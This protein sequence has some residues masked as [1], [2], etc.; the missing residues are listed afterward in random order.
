MDKT[1]CG[2]CGKPPTVE[3]RRHYVKKIEKL[4]RVLEAAR[5]YLAKT[6]I[7]E[8]NA[9]QT[10][11]ADVVLHALDPSTFGTTGSET[12]ASTEGES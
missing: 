8:M 3:C 4:Q 6:P 12:D 11:L 7:L 2:T 1:T 5:A 9:D 10:A